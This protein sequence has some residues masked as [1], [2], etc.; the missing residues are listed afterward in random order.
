MDKAEA[1][2]RLERDVLYSPKELQELG[3]YPKAVQRLV[4]AGE[5]E[6]L[7]RGVYVASGYEPHV[8]DDEAVVAKRCPEAVFNLYTAA[9]FHGIT[10]VVPAAVWIGLPPDHRNPPSGGP[11][12][13]MAL[14]WKRAL[15]AEAGIE[16]MELR[17]VRLRFTGLE[18]TVIDM[19]RYSAHNP[20]LRSRPE[21][22]DDE[23]LFQCMG[24]YLEKTGGSSRA[25]AEMAR[26]LDLGAGT[27]DAFFAFCRRFIGGYTY[28]NG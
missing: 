16:E 6:S 14:R 15:D 7:A 20:G 19:W 4:E 23:N 28:G 18:R 17:G 27:T 1:I 25:L 10:Q 8:L 3:L 24:A 26:K 11:A 9:R 12:P 22:I 13:V 5:M 2:G 21:R